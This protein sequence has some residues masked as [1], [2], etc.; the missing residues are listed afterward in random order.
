MTTAPPREGS[1]VPWSRVLRSPVSAPVQPMPVVEFMA[2]SAG[3]AVRVEAAGRLLDICDEI[4]APVE[5]SCRAATCGTCRVE[6][7]AGSDLLELPGPDEQEGLRVLA[8]PPGQRLACQV[9]VRPGSGLVR[10]RWV[11]R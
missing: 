2:S 1:G 11:G 3:P 6:V 7:E 10:L 5:F 9:M 4:G 8:V